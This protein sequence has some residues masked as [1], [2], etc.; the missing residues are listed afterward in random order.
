[1]KIVTFAA[2][3]QKREKKNLLGLK[4]S[5][6]HALTHTH[7][8]NCHTHSSIPLSG[9]KSC[10][11]LIV[12]SVVHGPLLL[13]VVQLLAVAN[14]I[15][16][17]AIATLEETED[18]G[19]AGKDTKT[20]ADVMGVKTDAD[21]S[22]PTVSD[23]VGATHDSSMLQIKDNETNAD[24]TNAAGTD[25]DVTKP[26]VK[27]SAGVTKAETDDEGTSGVS[28]DDA[29]RVKPGD[30]SS[31]GGKCSVVSDICQSGERERLVWSATSVQRVHTAVTTTRCV[32]GLLCPRPNVSTHL[33]QKYCMHT[34]V[35]DPMCPRPAVSTK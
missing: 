17:A 29:T 30:D 24:V 22:T 35:H 7:A 31:K 11:S 8:A 9:S 23:V 2:S 14:C 13:S 25:V 34:C 16:A 32:V 6:S 15:D 28:D 18:F 20:E 3:R 33:S 19:A 5:R 4:M 1:M 12:L 26:D 21:V 10:P 27:T